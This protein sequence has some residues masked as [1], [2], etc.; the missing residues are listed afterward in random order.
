MRYFSNKL[1]NNN[2]LPGTHYIYS[3]K[4]IICVDVLTYLDL[5]LFILY[6]TTSAWMQRTT[7]INEKDYY[8]HDEEREAVLQAIHILMSYDRIR[9]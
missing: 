5:I 9:P 6:V 4:P 7:I 2:K 3:H 1:V 8:Q